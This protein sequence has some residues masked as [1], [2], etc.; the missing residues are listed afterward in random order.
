MA[1][2]ESDPYT[3][4]SCWGIINLDGCSM[5]PDDGELCYCPDNPYRLEDSAMLIDTKTASPTTY[6]HTASD[7][8]QTEVQVLGEDRWH[9]LPDG[10]RM[11][12][13][14]TP[15]DIAGRYALDF[16]AP[17]PDEGERRAYRRF[18]DDYMLPNTHP[19]WDEW[20]LKL[21]YPYRAQF[22]ISGIIN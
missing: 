20:S 5:V 9:D 11:V 12:L 17:R 3:C 4:S 18:H 8:T 1:G 22:R 7:G 10:R 13:P 15:T 6:V 16:Y 21:T 19:R 14:H 2:Y